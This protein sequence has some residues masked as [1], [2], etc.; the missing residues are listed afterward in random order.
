LGYK[1]KISMLQ[2]LTRVVEA[3]KKEL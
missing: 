1:P 3:R 2:G